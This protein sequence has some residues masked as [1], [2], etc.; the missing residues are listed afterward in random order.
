MF[1]VSVSVTKLRFPS[2]FVCFSTFVDAD[3][4]FNALPL[5]RQARIMAKAK[6]MRAL[7]YRL[8]T[9]CERKGLA[10]DARAYNELI[11][12]WNS[13]EQAASEVGMA[14]TQTGFDM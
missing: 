9:L 2:I 12:S 4:R 6:A 7:S 13:M 3:D 14:G 8:N 5:E 1:L 10:E 11:N